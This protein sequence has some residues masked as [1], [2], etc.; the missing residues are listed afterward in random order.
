MEKETTIKELQY[1]VSDFNDS[2]SRS[3]QNIESKV[4]YLSKTFIT[5]V[6][7]TIVIHMD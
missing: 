6:N 2:V 3:F 4:Q 5:R 1:K 7:V